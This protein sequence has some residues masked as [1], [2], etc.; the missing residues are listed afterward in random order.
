MYIL[1]K[2]IKNFWTNRKS[3]REKLTGESIAAH[4]DYQHEHKQET[5]TKY[6]AMLQADVNL[7]DF[8]RSF[9]SDFSA[10]YRAELEQFLNQVRF[11]RVVLPDQI[12]AKEGVVVGIK[13]TFNS[14]G[15]ASQYMQLQSVVDKTNAEIV[16]REQNIE[17]VDNREH[18]VAIL[19]NLRWYVVEQRRKQNQLVR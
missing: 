14:L 5:D 18:A 6:Q 9:W 16:E 12:C 2:T 3:M 10:Q 17:N 13:N 15:N 1:V 8:N 7:R 11:M 19:G 4:Y